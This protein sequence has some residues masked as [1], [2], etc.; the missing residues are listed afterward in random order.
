MGLKTDGML[1]LGQLSSSYILDQSL[2][3]VYLIS[4]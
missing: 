4:A 3:I 2:G 1:R